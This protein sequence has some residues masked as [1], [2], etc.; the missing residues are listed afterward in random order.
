[1]N[2]VHSV[3]RALRGR[4][5]F[6]RVGSGRR[7]LVSV[8]LTTDVFGLF[9]EEVVRLR[10]RRV[11]VVS[12]WLGDGPD[13]ARVKALL[14][15]SARFGASVVLTTRTPDTEAH[16]AVMDAFAA[17]PGARIVTNDDLH[18]KLYVCSD[19]RGRGVA[20][21]GSANLSRG[22]Q[23]LDESAVVIRPIA[24]SRVIRDLSGLAAS[25]G[26]GSWERRLTASRIERSPSE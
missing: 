15:R 23:R 12:P 14:E 17:Y 10:P 26:G 3:Q 4:K 7:A 6:R 21:V 11:E 13:L 18:A 16:L 5:G 22:S 9:V 1:M 19:V 25:V 8:V 2:S 20:V 24:N